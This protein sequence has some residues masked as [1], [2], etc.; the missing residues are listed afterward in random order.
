MQTNWTGTKTEKIIIAKL[1][2]E[3]AKIGPN[4]WQFD[5]GGCDGD[6]DKILKIDLIQFRQNNCADTNYFK[7]LIFKRTYNG[8]SPVLI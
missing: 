2:S 3:W 8:H 1:R 6:D 7:L 5:G 4:P